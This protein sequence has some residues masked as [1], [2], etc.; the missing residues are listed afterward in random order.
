MYIM[1]DVQTNFEIKSLSD[2]PKFKHLMENLKMKINKSQLAREM[3]V[4]RRTVDKYLNGFAPK[5]T[6][7]KT[8]I[9]DE[10]YEVIAALLSEDSKQVFYYRHIF[11]ASTEF[12]H[13]KKKTFYSIFQ[14]LELPLLI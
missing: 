8:A 5:K 6:K 1:L 9:L 3:G 4:D 2:L 12:L 11:C 14:R 13:Y 10:Y 7:E